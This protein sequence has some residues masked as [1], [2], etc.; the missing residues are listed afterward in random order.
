MVAPMNVNVHGRVGWW[1]DCCCLMTSH[2]V[3]HLNLISYFFNVYQPLDERFVLYLT[4][5]P[6]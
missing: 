5:L 3:T 2:D 4:P 6:L 1:W